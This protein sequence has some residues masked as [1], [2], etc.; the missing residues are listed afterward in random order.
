MRAKVSRRPTMVE[1][2][3]HTPAAWEINVLGIFVV[4][5]FTIYP[6]LQR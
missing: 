2:D 4:L 5:S 3:F 1:V 6:P